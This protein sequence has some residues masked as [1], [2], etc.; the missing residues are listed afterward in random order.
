[1]P[2]LTLAE[3]QAMSEGEFEALLERCDAEETAMR[4]IRDDTDSGV[5]FFPISLIDK[6][7]LREYFGLNDDFYFHEYMTNGLP[8]PNKR[9]YYVVQDKVERQERIVRQDGAYGVHPEGTLLPWAKSQGIKLT[10]DHDDESSREFVFTL[11]AEEEAEKTLPNGRGTFG[12]PVNKDN[13]RSA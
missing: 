9:E 13:V 10:K 11:T 6:H 3:V 5:V 12:P 8:R 2:V 1:M 7:G 4:M